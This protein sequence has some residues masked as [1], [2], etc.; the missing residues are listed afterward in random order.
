M[1]SANDVLVYRRGAENA[2]SKPVIRLPL[3]VGRYALRITDNGL[4]TTVHGPRITDFLCELRACLLQ[5]GLC[6]RFE[7]R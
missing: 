4:R 1:S 7:I 5:A 6:G 3:S 2:E